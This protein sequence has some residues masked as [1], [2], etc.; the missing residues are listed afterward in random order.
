[1]VLIFGHYGILS[2]CSVAFPNLDF[3]ALVDSPAARL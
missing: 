2:F 3:W 1:M